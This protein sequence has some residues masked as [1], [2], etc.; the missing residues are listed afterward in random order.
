MQ[1]F[2]RLVEVAL[3]VLRVIPRELPCLQPVL[4]LFFGQPE[5]ESQEEIPQEEP[6]NGVTAV[7]NLELW[8]LLYRHL[9][10]RSFAL[11][12]RTSK[13]IKLDMEEFWETQS[14]VRLFHRISHEHS[15]LVLVGL[16]GAPIE[17]FVFV[18][19]PK[20]PTFT[21]VARFLAME[22]RM[23]DQTMPPRARKSILESLDDRVIHAIAEKIGP[24]YAERALTFNPIRQIARDS[25]LGINC[26]N[27]ILKEPSSTGIH[28]ISQYIV[29]RQADAQ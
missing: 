21:E 12:L 8:P 10:P 23:L 1:M 7:I 13:K 15:R 18:N 9:E 3:A 19:A 2:A 5:Q 4:T 14:H 16:A 29:R 25:R 27:R 11:L 26:E 20:H 22:S 24:D 6:R 28:H 17:Q